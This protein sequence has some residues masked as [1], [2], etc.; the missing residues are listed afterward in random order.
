MWFSGSWTRRHFLT[1]VAALAVRPRHAA[2]A[3]FPVHFRK[4]SPHE[5]LAQF[6]RPGSD[7][8]PAEK[9]AME[10]AAR[11]SKP[12]ARYYVLPDNQLRYEI[13]TPGEYRVGVGKQETVERSERPLFRDVPAELFGA[14]ESFREQLLRGIPYWRARLD[15]ASGIDIYGSNGIAAGDIDGDGIDEIFVCQPGGL[16][17]RLYKIRDGRFEDITGRAGV[18]LLDDTSSALFL[19][20]RNS[21]RQDLVV[22]RAAGPVLYLNQGD[23]V[24]VLRADAFQFEGKPQGSFTGISAADY[25]RDGRI[26]L[27]LCTY[28]YFQSE[29]QYRYP[30]PYHDA[31]N[32]PP[33]FLFRNRLNADGSGQFE[34]V[35]EASGLNQNNDCFSFAAAWCDY[36]GDGWPD[37]YVANDFGRNNLYRNRNGHFEDVAAAAGVE[38]L[39]PGMSAT[40]FDYDGDGRP[41]LY[42]SNMWSD[43]GQRI[44]TSKDLQPREMWQRHAKGNSLFRSRGDETFEE[45]GAAEG[46]EMGRWAWSSGGFDFDNDGSPEIFV[47]TG[48]LTNESETD[49]ESFFWRKVAA[50]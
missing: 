24:F 21:G 25:D 11:F 1:T 10:T 32:G 50:A 22:L 31:R 46:V 13:K 34:D 28:T 35:T 45:T 6:I 39:G 49:L 15:P 14:C 37:L 42:V 8:F 9:S 27:Y 18:G 3:P 33:N 47:T 4:S 38:D 16:P 30:A 43:A 12:G 2:A 48:M 36:D 7:E 40:W 17:N 29:D 5:T 26:D 44:I 23:G 19:A 41:D 20:L